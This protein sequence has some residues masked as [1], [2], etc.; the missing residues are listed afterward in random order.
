[1]AFCDGSGEDECRPVT[2]LVGVDGAGICRMDLFASP[3]E[4]VDSTSRRD[5]HGNKLPGSVA[6]D[7]GFFIDDDGGFGLAF[8]D[9]FSGLAT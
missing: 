6:N 3:V 5:C 2:A 7:S 9:W 1:M 4:K 8:A